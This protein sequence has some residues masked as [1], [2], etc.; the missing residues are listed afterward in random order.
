[1]QSESL[2]ECTFRFSLKK[3]WFDIVFSFQLGNG[4]IGSLNMKLWGQPGDPPLTH[5][6]I[7]SEPNLGASKGLINNFF[8]GKRINANKNTNTFK[9]LKIQI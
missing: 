6:K 8:S 1:M 3:I 9:I 2:E 7:K 4:F 5:F